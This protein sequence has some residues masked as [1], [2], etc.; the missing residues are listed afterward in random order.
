MNI[1]VMSRSETDGRNV[2]FLLHDYDT[3]IFASIPGSG[4]FESYQEAVEAAD[5]LIVALSCVSD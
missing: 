1:E 4:P 3:D 2:Y 5:R